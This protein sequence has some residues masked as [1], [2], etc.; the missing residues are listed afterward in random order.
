MSVQDVLNDFGGKVAGLEAADVVVGTRGVELQ[1][2]ELALNDANT[3]QHDA[4]VAAKLS[5]DAVLAEVAKLG[6]DSVVVPPVDDVPVPVPVAVLDDV[7]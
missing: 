2:A 6:L 5:F 3:V 1:D 7:V 4:K